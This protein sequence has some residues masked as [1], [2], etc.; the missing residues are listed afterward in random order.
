MPDLRPG[1]VWWAWLD[2]TRG[3]EQSGRRPVVVVSSEGYLDVVTTLAIVVPVSRV[4][5][6]WPNHVRL[7]GVADLGTSFAMT[8]QPR[9]ISRERLADRIGRVDDTTLAEIGTWLGDFLSPG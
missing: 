1:D 8:E 3:R 9:T 4:D 5:R 6:G 7:R 2:P